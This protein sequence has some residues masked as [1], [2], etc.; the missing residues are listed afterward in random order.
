[1]AMQYLNMYIVN[2]FKCICTKLLYAIPIKR[3][4]LHT[5]FIY[6]LRGLE[7]RVYHLNQQ[8]W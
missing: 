1:M 4:N 5:F 6:P 2:M 3:F 8:P 7:G